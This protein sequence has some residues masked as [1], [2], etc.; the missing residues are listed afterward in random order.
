MTSPDR[1]APEIAARR[2]RD[3]GPVRDPDALLR[4]LKSLGDGRAA[5]IAREALYRRR[6]AEG[7]P[8]VHDRER[9]DERDIVRCHGPGDVVVEGKPVLEGVNGRLGPE[10]A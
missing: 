5:R 10:S 6:R 9:G 2:Y 7:Q 3:T 8:G 1:T 4:H